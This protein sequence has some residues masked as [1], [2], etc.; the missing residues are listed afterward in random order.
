MGD[1][2]ITDLVAP[3]AFEQL[4]ELQ[5]ELTNT[6]ETFLSVIKELGDVVKTKVTSLEDVEKIN[7]RTQA[8]YARAEE[9]TRKLAEASIATAVAIT[10][11]LKTGPWMAAIVAAMG[12]IQIATILAT[13][14]KAYAKGTPKEGHQGGLAVV[15]DGGKSE[16]VMFGEKVWMTPDTPTLVDLPKGAMVYPDAYEMPEFPLPLSNA[17]LL[18]ETVIVNDFSRLERKLDKLTE[19][20]IKNAKEMTKTMIL[21][22]RRSVYLAEFEKYIK[23]NL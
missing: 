20:Q 21:E 5:A 12:A 17:P 16:I 4:K 14:I 13:P 1:I 15:G 8:A 6:K 10:E 3:K 11:A 18:P 2:R 23:S 19:K 9:A 22:Q 7:Q